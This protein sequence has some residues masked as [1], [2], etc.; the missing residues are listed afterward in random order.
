MTKAF[1]LY[2]YQDEMKSRL[3]EA[4]REHRSVMLQMPTGTGKTHVLAAVVREFLRGNG[5]GVWIIAHR[6]ELVAQAE[7]T[8]GRYGI[9]RDDGRV[10]VL[11]VQ[12]LSRHWGDMGDGRPGLVV[13]DEAHHARAA[14]YRTLWEECPQAKFLG[15]TATPCRMD[16]SGF[17]GLFEVL[18]A[19]WSV[20]EFIR[21]GRLSA[22]DYVTVRAG[23]REQRL[24]DSLEKRG[25]DGDY[26][27]KEMDRVLNR[28]P[29]I[30]RLYE[31]LREYAEGRKGI[32]YAVSISHARNIAGYYSRRGISAAAIDGRT[33]AAERKRLVEEFRAGRIRVLVNVDVFSEGFDCPDVEFVQMAR[34]TLSLAR[35]LQQAG[36][37]L[38][39]SEGKE[40][41]V[42]ID[43]VGLYRVFGLPAATRDWQAM[44]RGEQTGRGTRASSRQD[45]SAQAA[46]IREDAP[47]PDNGM[48]MVVSH[49]ELLS[50]LERQEHARPAPSGKE[51]VL[52]AWQDGETGL[53]GLQRGRARTTGAAFATVFDIRYGLAAVRFA[54]RSCGITGADGE[55]LWKRGDCRSMRFAGNRFLTVRTADGREYWL[56]LYSMRMY[57]ERP[58]VRRYGD[59]ELLKIGSTFY[60]RTRRVYVNDWDIS[61]ESISRCGFGITVFD[62]RAAVSCGTPSYVKGHC[63]GYACVLNGDHEDYYWLYR[64]LADGT[65][66]VTDGKGRYYHVGEGIEKEYIGCNETVPEE[67]RCRARVELIAREAERTRCRIDAERR[68]RLLESAEDAVPFRSGTKWGLKVGG[69]VTV[70]PI[71]RS[72]RPP[73]GRYCAVEK[74]YSRWGVVALDGTLVVEPQYS[75]ME[76]S[77]QGTATGTK[78][79]GKKVSVELP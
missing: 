40:T 52:K 2:D 45:A 47:E 23:S 79:T 26:R 27:I 12:W 31:S 42:L 50:V 36:R 41:C 69:R 55:T 71:Y 63:L 1:R 76:I 34:P 8:L 20:A 70:P 64:R 14:T 66:V 58:K 3:T 29:T 37:G 7:E 77:A 5:G 53:W 65:A 68:Q 19:S 75:D 6:R 35:Y 17:T 43:N 13:I 72:V 59:V 33:P 54:D 22:F 21:K 73:V 74:D 51:P 11:A 38:R 62:Y 24:V 56:D 32:V 49:G 57:G 48:E 9:R 30:V 44:F 16:G 67:E 25:A 61:E 46:A 15:L 10:R 18:L 4:W 60:S 39:R 78:V 28:H